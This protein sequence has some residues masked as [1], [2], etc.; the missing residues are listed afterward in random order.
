MSVS[1]LYANRPR[2]IQTRAKNRTMVPEKAI[3]SVRDNI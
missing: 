3:I 2:N 1:F